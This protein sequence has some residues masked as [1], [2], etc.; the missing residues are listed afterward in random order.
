[1]RI[2]IQFFLL[3]IIFTPFTLA[4][5]ADV[6]TDYNV[7]TRPSW[8]PEDSE[9]KNQWYL[10]DGIGGTN[11]ERV[12]QQFTGRGVTVAVIDGGY[13]LHSD[14]N[15]AFIGGYDFI[16]DTIN[17]NDGNGRDSDA[18]DPGNY[19][20][21]DQGQFQPS[22][23]HGL[24]VSGLIGARSNS[25]GII[26]VAPE[27]TILPVRVSGTR[28]NGQIAVND[29]ID[30]I[31]WVSGVSLSDLNL[32]QP[33][34]TQNR[35]AEIINLSLSFNG[36]NINCP[37]DLQRAINI[38]DTQDITI[39]VSAGNTP[40][41][42]I[43]PPAN[44]DNVITVAATN[45][46]GDLATFSQSGPQVIIS[47]PGED[48]ITLSNTG[49]TT[50]LTDSYDNYSDGTSLSAPLVA[51]TA[52]LLY[53]ISPETM[54]FG[55]VRSALWNGAKSFPNNSTCTIASCGA[56]IIDIAET[57]DSLTGV[58]IPSFEEG[59]ISFSITSD[60]DDEVSLSY[61]SPKTDAEFC[62]SE[63]N[64]LCTIS[65]R[66]EGI[67]K[68]GLNS[69]GVWVS[70]CDRVVNNTCEIDISL[71]DSGLSREISA[72]FMEADSTEITNLFIDNNENYDGYP[73]LIETE[74][75]NILYSHN[76]DDT[77]TL[78][79]SWEISQSAKT[80]IEY[81][82]NSN[83]PWQ[84]FTTTNSG[85]SHIQ[86]K[87]GGS[88]FPTPNQLSSKSYYRHTHGNPTPPEKIRIVYY[89]FRSE[90]LHGIGAWKYIEGIWLY[91]RD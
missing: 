12:W 67:Y 75:N 19:C 55:S 33:S 63:G 80:R 5:Q 15:G 82:V 44:C 54:N 11:A 64:R 91:Y 1:M 25:T 77:Y 3:S 9:Y 56:G 89:R 20:D 17:A 35:R 14:L 7:D 37:S 49:Q 40:G 29:L 27:S 65:V 71:T 43:N 61:I 4:Q 46:S 47:A 69:D 72:E 45:Q 68:F 24:N 84:H 41:N 83:G 36:S 26:G 21:D 32:S 66:R 6:C 73:E 74:T 81:K 16:S 30:A 38:A 28:C 62:H 23:W 18:T 85:E 22:V 42:P 53:Q 86:L 52:A 90:G 87:V 57:L 79:A 51:G 70:G 76:L 10:H 50:S 59:S 39:I 60:T 78:Y 13:V 34:P 88:P 58:N 31:Y 2:L 48:I 8:C